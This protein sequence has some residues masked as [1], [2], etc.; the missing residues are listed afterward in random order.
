[1]SENSVG[2][3]GG[4]LL[5]QVLGVVYITVHMEVLREA[6]GDFHFLMVVV[7]FLLG[8]AR[9]AEWIGN[10]LIRRTRIGPSDGG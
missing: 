7:F 6:L 8:V 5:L 4:M 1:M 10:K 2:V 3:R 9:T